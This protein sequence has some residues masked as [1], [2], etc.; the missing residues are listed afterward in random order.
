MATSGDGPSRPERLHALDAVRGFALLLGIVYH[1]AVSFM[2]FAAGFWVIVDSH[3]S[4]VLAAFIFVSH[5]FRM[6]T[7]FVVAGFFAHLSFHR[8]GAT[9][10]IYDR[11]KRIALPLA[12]GLPILLILF[13]PIFTAAAVI[14]NGGQL[15]APP[16]PAAI[17]SKLSLAHLWF[18]YVLLEFYVVA[19]AL[20]TS[21]G[22][23]DR[24][25]RIRAGADRMV[26]LLIRTGVAPLILATPVALCFLADPTWTVWIGIPTPDHLLTNP[27]AFVAYGM[28]FGFGW[29]LHRQPELL[30]NLQQRWAMN[31]M[32]AVVLIT[33][34][35]SIALGIVPNATTSEAARLLGAVC[36]ALAGW[37]ATF[38]LM[39]LAL[40][41]L[42]DYSAMRR[43]IA[44]ASYWLYLVH[45]PIVM[46]LQVAVARLD[47]PWP[48]KYAGII[49]VTFALCFA[50]YQW[51]VR[52]SFVGAVLNGR[53]S[54]KRAGA[55][56]PVAVG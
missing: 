27:Q 47:W 41:F 40:R 20:R 15:P 17:L 53:R 49:V 14:K 9:E 25:G 4:R 2:P 42:S 26:R 13:V 33:G 38:A 6:T 43:Y 32:L 55:T 45:L 34:C 29:M 46:A 23:L 21:I 37:T 30:A 48:V 31:L 24:P 39:G 18:L 10:F 52:Y 54:P 51:L 5:T 1:A 44:D 11:L 16:P 19:L 8:L 7:F 35:V 12:A 56:R 28:A 50:S 3:P 36:Y 22:W